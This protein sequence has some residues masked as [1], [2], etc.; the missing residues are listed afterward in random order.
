M[1][2]RDSVNAAYSFI[3]ISFHLRRNLL[4]MT[5]IIVFIGIVW[6]F[7]LLVSSL[8]TSDKSKGIASNKS[9]NY[10]EKIDNFVLQGFDEKQRI[11]HF[12]KAKQYFNFDNNPDLLLA[13]KVI[14]YNK[15]GAEIYTITS[16]RAQYLDTGEVKF[17]GEVDIRSKTGVTYKINAKELSINTKTHD[18]ISHQ[19]VIYFDER[20]TVV[21]EGVYVKVTEDKMQLKGKNR[22]KQ[23]G[24][25]RIF[26]QDLFI[27]QSNQK[28]HYYS[29]HNTTYLASG[30]KINAQGID[31]DMKKRR[32]I[33]LGKVKILQKS[34]ASIDTKFLTVDR[35]SGNEIYSTKEK[36]HYQSKTLNIHSTG[37]YYNVKKQKIKLT[38][39]V[40]GHYE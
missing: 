10:I 15:S 6:L 36:V 2:W 21:A 7:I 14:T 26:T 20:A 31:M 39:G 30:N 32:A 35:S 23:E 22:I 18:L 33:L 12:I 16:K 29:K 37:M 38:G 19:E 17:K 24:G 5:L 13:P 3:M 9:I 34:G 8:F 11:L 40:V 4:I 1:V 25:Q 27:D 28:K